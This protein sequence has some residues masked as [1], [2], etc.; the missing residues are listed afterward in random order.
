MNRDTPSLAVYDLVLEVFG[1]VDMASYELKLRDL[2]DKRANTLFRNRLN[3][4]YDLPHLGEAD[5]ILAK[6]LSEIKKI[7]KKLA[8]GGLSPRIKRQL[9]KE[10]LQKVAS[11]KFIGDWANRAKLQ[12]QMTARSGAVVDILTKTALTDPENIEFSLSAA[13]RE[14][15]EALNAASENDVSI[16]FSEDLSTEM[17]S[18]LILLRIYRNLIPLVAGNREFMQYLNTIK[19]YRSPAKLLVASKQGTEN[20][21]SIAF[22]METSD[23]FMSTLDPFLKNHPHPL[24]VEAIHEFIELCFNKIAELGET[25]K[26]ESILS[27]EEIESRQQKLIS[28]FF[29]IEDEIRPMLK[30]LA[31]ND[32]MPPTLPLV[33]KKFDKPAVENI[34]NLGFSEDSIMEAVKILDDYQISQLDDEIAPSDVEESIEEIIQEE[35]ET[36]SPYHNEYCLRIDQY[37]HSVFEFDEPSFFKES[38]LIKGKSALVPRTSVILAGKDFEVLCKIAILGADSVRWTGVEHLIKSL[39]G[40]IR[41]TTGSINNVYIATEWSRPTAVHRPHSAKLGVPVSR[42]LSILFKNWGIHI[43]KFKPVNNDLK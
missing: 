42:A 34:E 33:F 15:Q 23:V 31:V 6:S 8:E 27:D 28:Y 39:G 35:K 37:R 17:E 43:G 4:K 2:V 36:P 29:Q 3:G 12:D 10:R 30:S 32:R 40:T 11:A 26:Q 20:A 24:K 9:E 25:I 41:P 21:V 16:A 1:L 18:V 13:I 38:K 22:K 14:I 5:R 19:L 7:D